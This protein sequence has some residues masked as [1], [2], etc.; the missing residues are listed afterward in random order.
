MEEELGSGHD[1]DAMGPLS[2]ADKDHD[3][4]GVFADSSYSFPLERTGRIRSPYAEAIQASYAAFISRA[5]L[6]H[7]FAQ[8]LWAEKPENGDA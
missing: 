6:S 5:A 7:D 1:P 8:S 3:L 2:F 4:C